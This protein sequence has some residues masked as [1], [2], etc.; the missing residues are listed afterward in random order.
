MGSQTKAKRDGIE[1]VFQHMGRVLTLFLGC[2]SPRCELPALGRVWY[3]FLRAPRL[4]AMNDVL[5]R[6][7]SAAF[8]HYRQIPMRKSDVGGTIC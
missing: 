3:G 1:A 4:S 7:P 8:S 6:I 2:S 5:S